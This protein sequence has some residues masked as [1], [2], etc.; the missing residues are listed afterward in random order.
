MVGEMTVAKE[1]LLKTVLPKGYAELLTDIKQRIRS[2]QYDALKAVNKEH[3]NLYWDIGRMIVEKQKGESWGKSIVERLAEDL[4]KEFPSV[5]GFSAQNLWRMRQ[6][7]IEYQSDAKLSPLVRE[8]SWSHNLV[9]M[10]QCKDD[11]EREFYIRM[12][13]DRTVVEYALRTANKPIGVATYKV[14]KQLPSNLKS[15]L[16]APEQMQ[17]LMEGV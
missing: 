12:T 16:P 15:E 6:F 8:I 7:F 17:K 9:I 14:V 11:V 4:R 2:A 13:K 5:A 10:M 3:I 1:N